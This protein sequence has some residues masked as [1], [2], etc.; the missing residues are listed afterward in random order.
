MGT[1]VKGGR[2]KLCPYV[3]EHSRERGQEG[4]GLSEEQQGA[5][6][7]CWWPR[8]Q[9]LQGHR[10]RLKALHV[11]QLV[12]QKS[13]PS[14]TRFLPSQNQVPESPL[15]LCRW[16]LSQGLRRTLVHP[17]PC[18][19]EGTVLRVVRDQKGGPSPGAGRAPGRVSPF[20][21]C[22]PGSSG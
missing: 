14:F 8:G 18:G 2:R 5:P 7:V 3:W 13:A 22:F 19:V 6:D 16:W 21:P 12:H 11:H 1:S 9:R 20:S 4:P 10:A 17:R 15:T